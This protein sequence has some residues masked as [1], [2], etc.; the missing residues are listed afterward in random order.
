MPLFAKIQDQLTQFSN[1]EAKIAQVILDDPEAVLEMTAQQLALAADSSSA[2][3]IRLC[4]RLEIQGFPQLKIEL[5]GDLSQHAL[6]QKLQPEV[7][8]NE[9]VRSIKDRLLNN[10]QTSL[11]KTVNELDDEQIGRVGKMITKATRLLVF[12][13]GASNL[14]ARNIAQKWSRVGIIAS[15]FSDLNELLPLLANANKGDL[16]W[17]ISNSG[18]S[19]EAIHAAQVAKLRNISLITMTKKGH[20]SVAALSDM[21]IHTS[22]P[23]EMPGRI[24]ATNSLLMQFMVIDIIFYD[25][26]SRNYEESVPQLEQSQTFVKEYKQEFMQGI[27]NK[28]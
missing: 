1:S 3:V 5:S 24:A 11:Q 7:R 26:V 12:G 22:Q 8:K 25:Y 10:A 15:V 14:A 17:V 27:K 16:L 6:S 4:K 28:K 20:N 21:A 9:E 13:T 2:A 18:E 19:P 23:I